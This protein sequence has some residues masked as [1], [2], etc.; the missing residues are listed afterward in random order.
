[1]EAAGH[2]VRAVGRRPVLALLTQLAALAEQR[3]GAMGFHE[4]F[5][6]LVERSLHDEADGHA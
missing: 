6:H 5:P 4:G 3:L 1:M 2:A